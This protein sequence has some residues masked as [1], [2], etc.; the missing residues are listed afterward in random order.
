MTVATWACSGDLDSPASAQGLAAPNAGMPPGADAAGDSAL[1]PPGPVPVAPGERECDPAK[2]SFAP[3]RIWQLSDEQYVNV[4]RDV[5]GIELQ[6]SDARIVSAVEPETYTNYSEGVFVSA[7]VAPN[8]ERVAARVGDQVAARRQE[9]LGSNAPTEVEVRNFVDEKISRAWRRPVQAQEADA[10]LQLYDSASADPATALR[11]LVQ[12]A[13]QMPSFVYRTELGD[14]AASATGPV[15]MT[16]FEIASALSFGLYDSAPDDTLWQKAQDGSLLDPG[17]R[18]QEVDRLLALPKV[19]ANLTRKASYWLSLESLPNK[20]KS[21]SLYPE[22]TDTLKDSLYESVQAFLSEVLWSGTMNDLLTSSRVYVNEEM[23]DAYAIPG[24]TGSE[25]TPVESSTRTAGILTQP[26]FLAAA[27]KWEDRGDPI[28]R[29]LF[30]YESFICGGQVPDPP[31]DALG[32]GEAMT[33]SEREKADQR[34]QMPACVACHSLFDPVG[35]TFERYDAM[36]RYSETRYVERDGE[37]GTS[38]WKTSPAPIDQSAVIASSVGPDLAGPVNGVDELAAK[39][40]AASGRV[41]R[42]ASRR[43]AEYTL[44]YNPDAKNACEFAAVRN[45]FAESGSFAEFFRSLAVSPAFITRDSL[46]P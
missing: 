27:N 17:V 5:F 12:A 23:S 15:V 18:A 8:Y 2:H 39:L 26:G 3:A 21:G 33:G 38:E 45:A 32:V 44:G 1:A 31:A 7:Q 19:R 25:L 42:C 36:G 41:A 24:G 35:L 20:E 4:V 28:H 16:P 30:L 34:G 10:L 13:L 37:T 14:N 43:L 46:E 40:A 6:G 29:G 22:F 11:L 9:L